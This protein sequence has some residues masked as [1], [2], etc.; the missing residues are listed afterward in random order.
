M[1]LKGVTYD[2]G[3]YMTFNWRPDF[4]LSTV[5][6]EL[7]II[8]ND[9]HCN[10]V[11]ITGS[12]LT[13]LIVTARSALELGLEVWLSPSI[14]DK[15]QQ[16]TLKNILKVAKEAEMLRNTLSENIVFVLGT[17][18]TLFMSGIIEGKNLS[19]RMSN[20]RLFQIIKSGE[21]NKPLNE[22]LTKA[23]TAVRQVYHG[24]V[25]YDSLVWEKVDWS[26]FDYIGVDHYR[27]TKIEDK[28]LEML[29]PSF[30]FEK[31]VV[32]T[33]F[34]YITTYGGMN[35]EGL[36]S[37]AGLGGNNFINFWS[38][39]L[40]NVIPIFGRLVRSRLNGV[41]TRDESWQAQKL[42]ETLQLLDSAGVDGAFVDTFMSQTRPF[43]ED[44]RYDLDM[45]SSSLVKYFERGGRGSTYPDMRWEP[46][47]SFKAVAEYYASH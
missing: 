35:E 38:L 29:E 31:P 18:L 1:R 32:I 6:S 40:H 47:E 43:S 25:S 46:K 23:K 11:R 41:H 36:L 15:N 22:Y 42:V 5:R 27:A 44:P 26:L 30:S 2:A 19:S 37:S 3:T 10:A 39:F 45:T 24:E 13:K 20:P 12:N 17:E 21:H 16:E 4:D 14:W 33:E 9:L 28:Y 7:R 8:R 34:G